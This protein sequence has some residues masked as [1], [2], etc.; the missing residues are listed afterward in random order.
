MAVDVTDIVISLSG[1]DKG[2][3]FLVVAAE[4]DYLLLADGAL[5]RIEKPKRKKRKHTQFL[6]HSSAQQRL[7]DGAR[8][9]NSEIRRVIAEGTGADYS[10]RGRN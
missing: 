5:R 8:L 2:K 7:K 6:A 1:R 4:G 10:E 9:S 3:A